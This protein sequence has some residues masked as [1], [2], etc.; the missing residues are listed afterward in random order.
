MSTKRVDHL[1]SSTR[2]LRGS[3]AQIQTQLQTPALSCYLKELN[4]VVLHVSGTNWADCKLLYALLEVLLWFLTFHHPKNLPMQLMWYCKRTLTITISMFHNYLLSILSKKRP[5][6]RFRVRGFAG[7]ELEVGM[8]LQGRRF[9]LLI[10]FACW[11]KLIQVKF[12]MERCGHLWNRARRTQ[13]SVAM[14]DGVR[15][16]ARPHSIEFSWKE[17]GGWGGYRHGMFEWNV[18]A[19][20]VGDVLLKKV[21]K[22]WL[23]CLTMCACGWVIPLGER[24][25]RYLDASCAS[26][27]STSR[28]WEIHYVQLTLRQ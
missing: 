1:S 12:L 7:G 13:S 11:A 20:L 23:I 6:W 17:V 24:G 8:T 5:G 21:Q 14:R 2:M 3:N 19:E 15:L 4:I 9:F 27:S 18:K 25:D 10:F 28:T 22:E 16:K 26:A